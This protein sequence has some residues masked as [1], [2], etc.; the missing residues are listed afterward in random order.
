ML[1]ISAVV[2]F[3]F[4][5]QKDATFVSSCLRPQAT[6]LSEAGFLLKKSEANINMHELMPLKLCQFSLI[7]AKLLFTVT[8]SCSCEG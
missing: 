7:F 2:F 5:F 3:F 1:M 8:C 6:Q 4:F